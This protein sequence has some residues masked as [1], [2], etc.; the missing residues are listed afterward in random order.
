[1][2]DLTIDINLDDVDDGTDPV[3]AGQPICEIT[4]VS[5]PKY[6]QGG[7]Y[8]Y[9]EV[10]MKPDEYPNKTLWLNLSTSPKALW[11]LKLFCKAVGL[12]AQ[13][14]NLAL[15][16]GR[17]IAPTVEVVKSNKDPNRDVNNVGPP[18]ASAR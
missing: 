1:M 16:I 6:S 2:Q 3:P 11:N 15:A 8:P 4:A 10:T 17:K 9:Y 12:P 13:K 5:D 14:P 18:Y 7:T